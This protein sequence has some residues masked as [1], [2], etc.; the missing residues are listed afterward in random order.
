M[1]WGLGSH[2][3]SL[4]GHPIQMS[5]GF[6]RLFTPEEANDLLEEVRPLVSSLLAAREQVVRLQPTLE[7][8][9]E[10]ALGNGGG[11]AAGE[12]LDLLQ[13]M[14]R[15]IEQINSYGVLMKDLQLGLLDFQSEREGRVV[16]LC[17]RHGE[18][19]V[20]HWHEIDTGYAARKPL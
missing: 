10:K 14:R 6:S 5:E 17:W 19:R 9:L 13:Q 15:T 1:A 18:P 12:A 7:P 8:V 4:G 16:F 3:I 11:Q 2:A 20:G